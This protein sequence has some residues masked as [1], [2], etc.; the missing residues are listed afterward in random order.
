MDSCS[1]IDFVARSSFFSLLI[2]VCVKLKTF[3]SMFPSDLYS[4]ISTLNSSSFI[5]FKSL[6]FLAEIAGVNASVI[7]S[8]IT[9]NK[10]NLLI[11]DLFILSLP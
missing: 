1:S 2:S 6:L 10:T 7:K 9:P 3:L 11:N 4:A 8:P 5:S